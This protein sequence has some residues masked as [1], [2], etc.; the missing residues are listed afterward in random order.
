MKRKLSTIFTAMLASVALSASIAVNA[1][2]VFKVSKG[3]DVV[4]IGGTIHLLTEKDYPLQSEFDKAYAAADEIYFETDI[5]IMEEPSFQMKAVPYITYQDGRNLQT[6]LKEETFKR[7]DAYMQSKGLPTQQFLPLNPTGVMLTLTIMQYQAMGFTAQ[8]VDDFYFKKATAD[9]KTI[10][11]FESPEEQLAIIGSFGNEDP[12]GL[13]DYTLEELAR[14]PELINAL[15]D[16]WRAGDMD[17][18]V[19]VGMESFD[20]YDALYDSL[21]RN[22]NDAWMAEIE[23]MFGDEG[24]ELI[25]VGALHLPGPDGVLTQLEKKGYKVEKL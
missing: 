17:K 13:I 11:W 16:S 6:G 25:L 8:G 3:D 1:A 14:G 5:G 20:E 15:H 24:T 22:R 7:L 2:P 9:S 10:G 21:I 4:Y 12:D 23:P 18:L 19:E